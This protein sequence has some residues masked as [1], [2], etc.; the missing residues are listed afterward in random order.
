VRIVAKWYRLKSQS[1]SVRLDRD[2]E[3]NAAAPRAIIS[4]RIAGKKKIDKKGKDGEMAGAWL[5]DR[6][7]QSLPRGLFLRRAI[8]L[9]LNEIGDLTQPAIYPTHVHRTSQ[10][11]SFHR[12]FVPSIP[13]RRP[14]PYSGAALGTGP[15]GSFLLGGSRYRS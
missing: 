13:S 10:A 2:R 11:I 15:A 4:I 6:S 5:G 8:L 1:N 14:R 9:C 12:F 3:A 7:E